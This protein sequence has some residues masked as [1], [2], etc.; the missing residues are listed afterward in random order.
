MWVA[1]VTLALIAV[2]A[3][4]Y[5]YRPSYRYL[6]HRQPNRQRWNAVY[7]PEV[8]PTVRAALKAICDAF[9][10][11]KDDAFRLQPDDRLLAIYQAAYP[12]GGADTMEF[13]HLC[14]S[15]TE[16][17]HVPETAL[18]R[19]RDPTVKDIINLCV[20]SRSQGRIEG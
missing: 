14:L 5:F 20:E 16:S 11:R 12:K 8:H 18:E 10:L 13:E 17:F 2:G 9:L 15:L 3:A 6:R 19:L 1:G 7:P 4:A